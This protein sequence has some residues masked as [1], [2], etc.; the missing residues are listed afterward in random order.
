MLGPPAKA[1]DVLAM[2]HDDRRRSGDSEHDDR[3]RV[4]EDDDED[5]SAR[6]VTIDAS[7]A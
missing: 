7:E 6:A 2:Q 4:V 5:A 3:P 1:P